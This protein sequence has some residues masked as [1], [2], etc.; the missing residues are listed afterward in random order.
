MAKV[1]KLRPNLDKAKVKD[2][3]DVKD[4]GFNYKNLCVCFG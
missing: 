2:I 1:Y 3:S 4:G